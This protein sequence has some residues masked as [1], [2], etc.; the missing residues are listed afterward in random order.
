MLIKNGERL[1]DAL[2]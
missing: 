2:M 1:T